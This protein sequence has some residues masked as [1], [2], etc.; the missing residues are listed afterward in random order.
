MK[1]LTFTINDELDV[2]EH[3]QLSPNEIFAVRAL[4]IAQDDEDKESFVRYIS[5]PESVRGSLRDMLLSLQ[6]KGVILRSYKIPQK[7]E[8]FDI[9]DVEFNK[10]FLKNVYKASF[11]MGKELFDH[12]PISTNI[13]GKTVML[14]GVSKKYDSLEDAYKAYGKAIRWKPE[15]HSEIIELVDW[16][17]EHNIISCS[18]ASFIVDNKWIDLKAIKEGDGVNVNYDTIRML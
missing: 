5:L 14:R 9:D 13:Q 1:H 12:Y 16:A 2:L 18:L 17:K 15:F 6:S 11:E 4:L 3:Y 7:G 10:N 8:A